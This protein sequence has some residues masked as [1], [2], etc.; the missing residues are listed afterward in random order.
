LALI[1]LLLLFAAKFIALVI[2]LPDRD[3]WPRD[4]IYTTS[5]GHAFLAFL[6]MAV[7]IGWAG[8]IAALF[9]MIT[10]VNMFDRYLPVGLRIF[11]LVALTGLVWFAGDDACTASQLLG[12]DHTGR[13]VF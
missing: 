8:G 7:N 4:T 11:Y 3:D 12:R 1:L 5:V 6:F 9:G 10:G 13:V 2:W